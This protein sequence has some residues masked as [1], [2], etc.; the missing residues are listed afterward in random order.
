MSIFDLDSLKLLHP[1]V[2][3]LEVVFNYMSNIK[4]HEYQRSRSFFSPL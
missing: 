3:K 1:M 4:L 2:A